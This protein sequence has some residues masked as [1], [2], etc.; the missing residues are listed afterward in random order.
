MMRNWVLTSGIRLVLLLF[1]IG[2][3]LAFAPPSP[4]LLRVFRQQHQY[5]T[6]YLSSSASSDD[7]GYSDTEIQD[8][9][10]LI[11][12]LSMERND[13]E[14]RTR[15]KEVL[16]DVLDQ[17][18]GTPARFTNLFEQTLTTIGEEVQ[19]EAKKKYFEQTV[20]DESS[21][22]E[23]VSTVKEDGALLDG[24]NT[25]DKKKDDGDEQVVPEEREKTP[26]ELQLWALIDLMVQSKTI[27]KRAN[28]DLGS[29]STL[30]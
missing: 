14:R 22:P 27:I 29:K 8:M 15:C 23:E 9:R 21:S 7:C 24:S 5:P 19:L 3:A 18:N 13:H 28:G 6:S 11:T 4:L 30:G 12:S 16:H 20:G 1:P 26:E 17:P 2:S 25:G 10:E